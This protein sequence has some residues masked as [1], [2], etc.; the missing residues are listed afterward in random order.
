M[1]AEQ[2]KTKINTK[3]AH[4]A[5]QELI[6]KTSAFTAEGGAWE[7]LLNAKK[8]L[9]NSIKDVHEDFKTLGWIDSTES[10]VA[11]SLIVNRLIG[12]YG[13]GA[14]FGNGPG[15]FLSYWKNNLRLGGKKY[16]TP[17]LTRVLQ[18]KSQGAKYANNPNNPSG[19]GEDE[20]VAAAWGRIADDI[21]KWLTANRETIPAAKQETIQQQ[22]GHYR[23]VLSPVVNYIEKAQELAKIL[24][25]SA[26]L[27]H[28]R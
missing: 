22:L 16:A 12:H 21:K 11:D 13:L 7:K 25:P 27:S 24:N 3:S 14:E 1:T 9:E 8:S 10:P 18:E 17:I 4:I 28:N 20:S 2:P 26:S 5:Q 6:A 23:E 19:V 15:G